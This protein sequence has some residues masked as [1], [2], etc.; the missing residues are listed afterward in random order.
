MNTSYSGIVSVSPYGS[1]PFLLVSQSD[2]PQ[3]SVLD[4]LML[5][6][7]PY[8]VYQTH[9]MATGGGDIIKPTRIK[10]Y[11][12]GTITAGLMILTVDQAIREAWDVTKAYKNPI[13]RLLIQ[14]ET[15]QAYN[16]LE[17]DIT[18]YLAGVGI[19]LYE[20]DLEYTEVSG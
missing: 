3:I 12:I 19:E 9:I 10:Q 15:S 4:D 16:G 8:L 13:E 2:F 18:Y 1:Y 5:N 17:F 6:D 11:G 14:Q 7:A 20:T